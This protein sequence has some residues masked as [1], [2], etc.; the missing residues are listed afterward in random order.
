MEWTGNAVK[1]IRLHQRLTQRQAAL[2]CKRTQGWLSQIENLGNK[3]LSYDQIAAIAPLIGGIPS[4][5]DKKIKARSKNCVHCGGPI[6][7][8]RGR[9]RIYCQNCRSSRTEYPEPDVYDESMSSLFWLFGE[10][11]LD[12]HFFD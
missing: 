10:D 6:E 7:K 12:L 2:L 11:M 3:N 9:P 5:K 4:L 8:T 1:A